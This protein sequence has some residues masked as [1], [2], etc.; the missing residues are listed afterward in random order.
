MFG[1]GPTRNPWRDGGCTPT[2]PVI[3]T[4]TAVDGDLSVAWTVPDNDGGALIEGYKVQ[5]T[6]GG[7]QYDESRQVVI[8]DPSTRRHRLGG[9]F[10]G[11]RYQVQVLAYNTNGSGTP[12]GELAALVITNPA[13]S[14]WSRIWPGWLIG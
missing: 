7:Q 3:D 6:W 2:A 10:P 13:E 5:W 14:P 9:L 8:T 12:S 11:T 4:T 1:D